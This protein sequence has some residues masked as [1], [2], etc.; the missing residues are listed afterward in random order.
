M[1]GPSD[2]HDFTDLEEAAETAI[3]GLKTDLAKRAEA[4]GADD[5]DIAVDRKDVSAF[6][7]G[8][9]IFVESRIIAVATGRP[10]LAHS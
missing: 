9:E 1:H 5:I 3:A 8:Q 2:K 7:D 4:A 6:T 10:R